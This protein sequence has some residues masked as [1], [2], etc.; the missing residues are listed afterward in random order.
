MKLFSFSL[1]SFLKILII[2]LCLPLIVACGS[3]SSSSNSVGGS[4]ESDKKGWVKATDK[5]AFSAREQH[6]AVVFDNKMWVIGGADDARTN[7]VWSSADGIN[8][9]IAN[10]S[11]TFKARH[12]HQAVVFYDGNSTKMWVIGGSDLNNEVW[13]STDGK[14]WTKVVVTTPTFS[15]RSDHQ[16]VVFKDRMWVIGGSDKN[17]RKNDVWSSGDG[18]IWSPATTNAKFS[19]RD[20]HQ[21]VVFK[22]KMWVIGGLGVDDSN[23][24]DRLNDVWSSDDGFTWNQVTSSAT[25]SARDSHQVVAFDSEMWV[26]GGSDKNGRK[27][28]VWSSTNG[29][30]WTATAT[31][32]TT[33]TSI[34]STA[35]FS[36]RSDHQSVVFDNKV[37]VIGGNDKQEFGSKPKN[38]VWHCMTHCYRD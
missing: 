16:V 38:D 35:S 13:S 27:N 23:N 7:D 5:A 3:S 1:P 30:T 4:S 2:A 33:S 22:N 12:S 34:I 36:A 6:Q 10:S 20:R 28:D 18:V 25:F 19:A 37:W 31:T 24:V 32:S 29:I 9:I 21:A 11:A 8:W 17:G 26:I 14:D 15:A